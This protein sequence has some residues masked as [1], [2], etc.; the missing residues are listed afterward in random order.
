MR[1]FD[2][3]ELSSGR[4]LGKQ[5][6]SQVQANESTAIFF[7]IDQ[8]KLLVSSRGNL[9]KR[10]KLTE[11]DQCCVL[12]PKIERVHVEMWSSNSAGHY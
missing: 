6:R 5:W 10:V 4:G 3:L 8:E 9:T 11:L 1:S 2:W 7:L 12:F